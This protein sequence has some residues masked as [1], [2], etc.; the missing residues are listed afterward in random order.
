M[1]FTSRSEIHQVV[2]RFFTISLKLFL[3]VKMSSPYQPLK[4]SRS[5]FSNFNFI[6]LFLQLENLENYFPKINYAKIVHYDTSAKRQT[7]DEGQYTRFRLVL[8]TSQPSSMFALLHECHIL[9]F[10]KNAEKV[11]LESIA[12]IEAEER[13]PGVQGQAL[14]EGSGSQAP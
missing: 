14:V 8:P 12:Q 9:L 1:G 6:K 4:G 3:F 13:G 7:F 5:S 2:T 11:Q 10:I